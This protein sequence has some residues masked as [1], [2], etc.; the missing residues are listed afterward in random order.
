[1]AITAHFSWL[2]KVYL[3]LLH[4]PR[5]AQNSLN[6][7]MC[8]AAKTTYAVIRGVIAARAETPLVQLAWV[9]LE[10]CSAVWSLVR[11]SCLSMY[12]SF[13]G[14]SLQF[15][16]NSQRHSVLLLLPK[17]VYSIL[18]QIC[19]F[20]LKSWLLPLWTCPRKQG[21]TKPS[22]LKCS[23][24]IHQICVVETA[25]KGSSLPTEREKMRQKR[26]CRSCS[27][28]YAL[29]SSATC[30]LSLLACSATYLLTA[31]L[32]RSLLVKT[33]QLPSVRLL[34]YGVRFSWY[35]Q[36]NVRNWMGSRVAW[37]TY[38]QMSNECHGVNSSATLGWWELHMKTEGQGIQIAHSL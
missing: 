10:G 17:L 18:V 6:T 26:K 9:P 22:F 31:W 29:G 36:L 20:L 5:T 16:L 7:L 4:V 11:N 34:A 14:R 38:S 33:V 1:M 21:C 32:C 8:L 2:V 30:W 25:G 13:L 15:I 24:K 27:L 37:R 19:L 35:R 3:L 12:S 28:T 23:S